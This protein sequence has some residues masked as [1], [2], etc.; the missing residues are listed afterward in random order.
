MKINYK[1]SDE[2]DKFLSASKTAYKLIGGAWVQGYDNNQ[3]YRDCWDSADLRV[4]SV[5]L[6]PGPIRALASTYTQLDA[7]AHSSKNDIFIDYCYFPLED[8]LKTYKAEH[9]PI[10][11]G[12]VSHKVAADYD[13]I[14]VS[15]SVLSES[16]NL[17]YALHRS[18]IPLYH[19]D[20]IGESF[21]LIMMGGISIYDTDVLSGNSGVMDV[22]YVG[23]AETN[24]VKILDLFVKAKK[25]TSSVTSTKVKRTLIKK[26]VVDIGSIYYPD[27][28]EVNYEKERIVS[29]K[30]R[31]DWVPDKVKIANVE[32]LN[33]YPAFENK[34]LCPDGRNAAASDV[35]ISHGCTGGGACHF[36]AEGAVCGSWHEKSI[37]YLRDSLD[38]TMMNTPSNRVAYYSFNSPYHSSFMDLLYEA[39]KRY[40]Q[41]SMFNLRL[42]QIAARPDYWAAAQILKVPRGAAPIEGFG[43]RIRNTFLNKTLSFKEILAAFK[44]FY[45]GNLIE[46]KVGMILTGYETEEDWAD[47]V[48]E[49]QTILDLRDEMGSTTPIRMNITP[50]I[51]YP[52]TPIGGLEQH[53]A[54]NSLTGNRTMKSYTKHFHGRVR[55]K[56]NNQGYATFMDQMIL[57]LG[58]LGTDIYEDI[59]VNHGF[60]FYTTRGVGKAKLLLKHLDNMGLDTEDFFKEKPKNWIFPTSMIQVKTKKYDN[61]IRGT[62]NKKASPPCTKT[63][64]D[65]K[66]SCYNCGFCKTKAEKEAIIN[67]PL[68][69]PRPVEDLQVALFEN[70]PMSATRVG[71]EVP[72]DGAQW[73]KQ[74]YDVKVISAI[75]QT[76]GSVKYFH[77]MANQYSTFLSRDNQTDWNWGSY[78]LDIRWKSSK[79][80]DFDFDKVNSLL[81]KPKIVSAVPA[82]KRGNIVKHMALYEIWTTHSLFSIRTALRTFDGMV[83]NPIPC[84]VTGS[85]V[86]LDKKQADKDDIFILSKSVTGGTKLAVYCPSWIS[87][88]CMTLTLTGDNY[89][90][91]T[92]TTRA[93]TWG[94]FTSKYFGICKV[95]KSPTPMYLNTSSPSRFCPQC[96]VKGLIKRS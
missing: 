30:T 13:L 12:N 42:D 65:L 22:V 7:L 92:K 17:F 24:F 34:I 37:E 53:G 82:D 48:R 20:R 1:T 2:I 45:Q 54:R 29:I 28:Y 57:D 31:Y 40:S 26:M 56:F 50:L 96:L 9:L 90:Q 73:A 75:L 89:Q 95:C 86:K 68:P 91:A 81:N 47:A 25:K 41:L 79:A 14:I 70:K 4:L 51:L 69:T 84:L 27:G 46:T 85:S 72:E 44:V 88:I 11:F 61:Y 35:L 6:S 83:Q 93:K 67:R 10:L 5:F 62:V 66:P 32:N 87:P 74:A 15:T 78:F 49:M 94:L 60:T 3:Q 16:L 21:P 23:A 43:D 59:I 80:P 55:F 64:K 38:K 63:W 33:D 77:S 36:C 39:A 71:Y 58:R 52:H 19:K 8:D 18:G 76:L